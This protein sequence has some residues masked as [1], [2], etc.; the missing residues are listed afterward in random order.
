MTGIRCYQTSLPKSFV[1][2]NF[3]VAR[4]P[5]PRVQS[6]MPTFLSDKEINLFGRNK[7]FPQTKSMLKKKKGSI[8][9]N[10]EGPKRKRIGGLKESLFCP[11]KD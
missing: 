3:I 2:P 1:K 6:H 7:K 8:I 4:H 10:S 11:E 5:G 9:L